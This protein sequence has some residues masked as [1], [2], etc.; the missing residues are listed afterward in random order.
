MARQWNCSRG[1][2][3][4]HPFHLS[5][6]SY[7]TVSC[8]TL[9]R[10]THGDHPLL[11]HLVIK[12]VSVCFQMKQDTYI[13]RRR[14]TETVFFNDDGPVAAMNFLFCIHLV[15][16]VLKFYCWNSGSSK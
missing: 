13:E 16:S 3:A 14:Q 10:H 15:I 9:L 6:S 1:F 4:A 12:L 2:T 11:E 8:A 5:V 7:Y